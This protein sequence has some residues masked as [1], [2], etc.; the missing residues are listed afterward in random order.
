MAPA[1]PIS[2]RVPGSIPKSIDRQW[3]SGFVLVASVMDRVALADNGRTITLLKKAV[4]SDGDLELGDDGSADENL[5]VPGGTYGRWRIS[6]GCLD[7]PPQ[8]C[9]RALDVACR[10]I[11]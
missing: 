11:E 10:I 8:A 6:S 1:S 9:H 3:L 7:G 5:L 2:R 4:S